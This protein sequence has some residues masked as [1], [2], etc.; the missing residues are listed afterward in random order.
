MTRERWAILNA[1]GEWARDDAGRVLTFLL[2]QSGQEH[3]ATL[4]RTDPNGGWT[5]EQFTVEDALEE[6]TRSP[7]AAEGGL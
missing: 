6:A 2:E 3:L 5:L 7:F 4:L 1:E